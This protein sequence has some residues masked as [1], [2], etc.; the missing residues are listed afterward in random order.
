M[1]KSL[2]RITTKEAALRLGI[3]VDSVQ[4]LMQ[5]NRLPIGFVTKKSK[6]ARHTYFIYQESLDAYLLSLKNGAVFPNAPVAS[7]R[8]LEEF[9]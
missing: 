1:D 8:V 6:S 3:G 7:G 4:L 5:Q 9:I 2:H